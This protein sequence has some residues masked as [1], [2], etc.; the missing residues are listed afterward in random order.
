VY[1]QTPELR[2]AVQM[3]GTHWE[4][5]FDPIQQAVEHKTLEVDILNDGN[6]VIN[7]R[8]PKEPILTDHDWP[9][10]RSR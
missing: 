3:R 9:N 5:K 2:N 7:V 10:P 4:R 1:E 6:K 8:E